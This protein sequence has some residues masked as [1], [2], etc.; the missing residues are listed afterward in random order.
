VI[1]GFVTEHLSWRWTFWLIEILVSVL[2]L[3]LH[4]QRRDCD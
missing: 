3:S 2:A 1:G 4:S